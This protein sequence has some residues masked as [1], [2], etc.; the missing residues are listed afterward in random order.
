MELAAI[1]ISLFLI[2]SESDEVKRF[3]EHSNNLP[4]YELVSEPCDGGLHDSGYSMT[5]NNRVYFK[6]VNEDGT[7]GSV[8]KDND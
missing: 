1:F 4:I 8:C 6:K 5:F 7:V 3:S 2:I